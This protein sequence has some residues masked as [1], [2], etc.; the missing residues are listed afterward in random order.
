MT[1][2]G[3][4]GIERHGDMGWLLA[5]DDVKECV[6]EAVQRRSV[7]PFGGENRPAGKREMRPVNERHPVQ[8]K[9]FLCHAAKINPI[10]A[11]AYPI[12]TTAK[13]FDIQ[14]ISTDFNQTV[15]VFELL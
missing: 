11:A 13:A 6:R 3:R 8:Q 5:F 12:S 14:N 4:L 2:R 1:L 9:Q 10:R 7:H 15:V